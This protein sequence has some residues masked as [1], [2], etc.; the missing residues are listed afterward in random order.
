M[1]EEFFSK[2]QSRKLV[3]ALQTHF[4]EWCLS[5][6]GKELFIYI[7]VYIYMYIYICTYIYIYI[8]THTHNQSHHRQLT[9][10]LYRWTKCRIQSHYIV[11]LM[12]QSKQV[13]SAYNNPSCTCYL[14]RDA[15]SICCCTLLYKPHRPINMIY[16]AYI[17][18]D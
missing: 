15:R 9:N 7:Y 4:S 10:L 6:F 5:C 3:L 18:R 8:Y 2:T 11:L 13:L 12:I 14:R 1:Y 16:L 17:Y